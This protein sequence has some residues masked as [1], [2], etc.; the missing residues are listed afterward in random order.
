MLYFKITLILPF[1]F[2][3]RRLTKFCISLPLGTPKPA[4]KWLRNGKELTGNEPGISIAE[5]GTVLIIAFVTPYDNG[6]YVCVAVNE[7]GRTERKYNLK[8]HG[9]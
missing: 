3:A 8:V 9:K 6:E 5:D 2:R 4:I 7:A 1:P